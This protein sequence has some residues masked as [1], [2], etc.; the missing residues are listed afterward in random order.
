VRNVRSLVAPGG[1]VIICEATKHQPWFDTTTA[2]IEGWQLF[3]DG[4]RSDGPLVASDSWR[5]LLLAS[6]FETAF[7]FPPAG[8]KAEILGQ[9]VILGAAARTGQRNVITLIQERTA[10]LEE[11]PP[12]TQA[13]DLLRDLAPAA[14]VDAL[15]DVVRRQLAAV[16]KL[17][18]DE[19]IDRRQKLMELGLDSLMALEVRGS[20]NKT[21]GLNTPLASTIIFDHPTVEALARHLDRV[22]FGECAPVPEAAAAAASSGIGDR[23][24][25]LSEKEAEALLLERLQS[26]R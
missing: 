11:Q 4:I 22:L 21:L 7:A 9:H 12:Q 10:E 6:G 17:R 1:I 8:S 19:S 2:L 18:P 14:R 24:A 23:I 25:D 26:L 16:L 20:L 5:E 3:E 15:I 13:A